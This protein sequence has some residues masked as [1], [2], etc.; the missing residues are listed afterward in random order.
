[1]SF[2]RSSKAHRN[3]VIAPTSIAWQPTANKWFKIRVIS[4]KST[5]MYWARFGTLQLKSF[6]I[7][8]Q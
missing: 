4:A 7:A 5:R 3:G 1:M 2:S 8:K 6:S